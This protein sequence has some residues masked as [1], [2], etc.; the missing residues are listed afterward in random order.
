MKELRQEAIYLMRAFA[1][2]GTIFAAT[3][4]TSKQKKQKN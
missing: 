3:T 4:S 2:L 1:N